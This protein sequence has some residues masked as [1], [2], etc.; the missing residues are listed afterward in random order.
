MRSL[1]GGLK[2]AR[3]V[4]SGQGAY[5]TEERTPPLLTFTRPL[6]SEGNGRSFGARFRFCLLISLNRAF[7]IAEPA[8]DFICVV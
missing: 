3:L 2:S 7:Y 1:R 4:V 5:S 8:L 6:R